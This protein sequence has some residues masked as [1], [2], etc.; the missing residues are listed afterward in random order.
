MK[1]VCNFEQ[2]RLRTRLYSFGE[3]KRCLL[4]TRASLRY[5]PLTKG[6]FLDPR[7]ADCFPARL[8]I[9]YEHSHI[10]PRAHSGQRPPVR[11]RPLGGRK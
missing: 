10:L 6:L 5:A 2:T 4:Q 1:V 11:K 7:T 8:V 3:A 9:Q